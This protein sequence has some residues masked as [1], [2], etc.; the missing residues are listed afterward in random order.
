MLD[1][2]NERAANGYWYRFIFP[3]QWKQVCTLANKP[4][5]AS[6]QSSLDNKP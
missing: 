3:R 5:G 6:A 4:F 1:E 2:K